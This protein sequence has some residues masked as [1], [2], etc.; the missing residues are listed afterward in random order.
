VIIDLDIKRT[1]E[2]FNKISHIR[3][4]DI[5]TQAE[6]SHLFDLLDRGKIS[7]EE[8]FTKLKEE[9]RYKGP[10]KE[11]FQAWNAM[12]GDVPARRLDL[13]V[14]AKQNYNTF[15]LSNTN[16][17]HIDM[18]EHDLYRGHGVKNFED[19]FDKVYYSCRI[20]MRKPDKE[21]F[22]FVLEQNSLKPEETVF[23]DDSIQ[24]VK[25]A[26]AC[27]INAYLLS[28]NMEVGTLLRELKLL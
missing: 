13:L 28:P 9:I 16:E 11:L 21:I 7:G 3:F 23:I 18:F 2:A 19:Y 14:E 4:E 1:I 20:G 5:Y 6:Q 17:L 22:E 8:F 12:L 10:D 24:H 25:G 27:G 15:L 26:G